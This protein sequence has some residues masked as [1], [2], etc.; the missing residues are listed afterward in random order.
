[1]AISCIVE[2]HGEVGA[3]PI[4]LRRIGSWRS[5]GHYIAIPTPIRVHRDRFLNRED[6]CSR[7]LQLAASKCGEDGWILVVLDSDDDCPIELATKVLERARKKIPHRRISVVLAVREFEAW[8]IGSAR[9]LR[10]CRGFAV[11]DEE[12][13]IDA[14]IPRN[15]KG[16]LRQRMVGGVYGEVTDQTAF[17]AQMDLEEAH[18]RCRSFQKLCAEWDR[19]FLGR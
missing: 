2:G 9:S 17:A 4:L 14:E 1:M 7:H 6:E 18:A 13:D 8:F 19:Q 12:L 15:A 3:L 16:W 5:P 10:G 11:T